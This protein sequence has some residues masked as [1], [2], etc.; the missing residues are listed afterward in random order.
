M[1]SVRLIVYFFVPTLCPK[2]EPEGAVFI[3]SPCPLSGPS[4]YWESGSHSQGWWGDGA[5]VLQVRDLSVRCQL[6]PLINGQVS[7]AA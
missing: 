7:Q 4:D 6:C 2:I 5:D 3:V 1:S